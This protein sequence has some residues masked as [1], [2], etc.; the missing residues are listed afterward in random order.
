MAVLLGKHEFLGDKPLKLVFSLTGVEHSE[1]WEGWLLYEL[2]LLNG[3][4]TITSHSGMTILR[5]DVVNFCELLKSAEEGFFE[6]TEPNFQV[7]LRPKKSA[8][9]Y[10][11]LMIFLDE[12]IRR[13]AG[14]S[15]QGVGIR[16]SVDRISLVNFANEIEVRLNSLTNKI[17]K[18]E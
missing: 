10:D 5:E 13:S 8:K 7:Y 12:G 4:A 1:A 9:H 14:Y 15:G 17:L 18:Q 2:K 11:E 3:D 6:P 16:L